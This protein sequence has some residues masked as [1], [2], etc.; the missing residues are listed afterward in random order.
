MSRRVVQYD[1]DSLARLEWPDTPYGQYAREYLTPLVER[2]AQPFI[3]NVS[4]T[5]KVLTVGGVPVPITVND[6]EYDNSYVC[7]PYTHYVSYAREELALLNNR[8]L[9]GGLSFLLTGI[10]W[11]L[12]RARFN[13][14][15]QINNWLLSTNLYPAL[16]GEQLTAVME[17]LRRE[18]PGYTLICRSLSHETSEELIGSLVNYGCKLVPSRQIYLLHPNSSGSKARWLLKRDMGLMAKHGYT[19]AGP[20]E[21]TPEDIPRIVELYKL[22]YIDKYSA[23]NPQFTEAFIALALE[24]KT[25]QVYGLRKEGR[26]DAV[27][28]FYEREGAMTAPLFGYDT[29]LPQSVGLYRMLS[30]VLIGLAG[31][32][33]LLLHESSGVG[34][35]KRNRGAAGATEYSAVYD[36]GTSLLN[37]C[38]WS[39]LELLL[40]RIGMPLI[41][42]LKL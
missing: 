17:F 3:A 2:G 22:L 12:R 28:G 25:L 41:Q 32:K 15:V 39:F 18:Y 29:D 14:V 30:A 1:L 35:F 8:L 40:R 5:V 16:S 24:Q 23:H 33:G 42:K 7:S 19:E 31:S 9:E 10:G 36:R 13:R 21:I 26:L 38:G 11:L 27:L 34:Q 37:R 20:E 4:T 6:T